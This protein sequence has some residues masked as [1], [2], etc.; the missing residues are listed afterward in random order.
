MHWPRREDFRLPRSFHAEPCAVGYL[1]RA[2]V[3]ANCDSGGWE[4]FHGG[5]RPSPDDLGMTGTWK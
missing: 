4:G 5:V 1:S 3:A 2:R